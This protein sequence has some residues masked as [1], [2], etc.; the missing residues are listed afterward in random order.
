MKHHYISITKMKRCMIPKVDKE[1]ELSY[2]A[3]RMQSGKVILKN[4]LKETAK[5]NHIIYILY[6]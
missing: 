2:F 5:V 6:F 4:S 3:G 1:L